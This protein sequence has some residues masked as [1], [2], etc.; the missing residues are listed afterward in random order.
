ML[1][2]STGTR[3]TRSARP[4]RSILTFLLRSS[5]GLSAFFEAVPLPSLPILALAAGSSSFVLLLALHLD[6][7][8]FGGE[9]VL[10]VL[11]Q[12]EAVDAGLA[13]GGEVELDRADLRLEHVVG[14]VVEV[15]ALGVEGRLVLVEELA[16]DPGDLAL[17]DGSTGRASGSRWGR[18]A[19]RRA[20]SSRATRSR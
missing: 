18:R 8:A 9:G 7:V 17:R 15:V 16:G 19:S 20:R 14:E 4:S 5:S 10:D 1:S 11:A 2:K 13:V 6:L 3:K 12:G